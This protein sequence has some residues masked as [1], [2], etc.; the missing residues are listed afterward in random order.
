M[1]KEINFF[2]KQLGEEGVQYLIGS[3]E[4]NNV[5]LNKLCIGF[6]QVIE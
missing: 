4:N 1:I 5:A 3:L 2:H 6:N